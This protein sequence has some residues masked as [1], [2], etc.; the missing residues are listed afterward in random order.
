[1]RASPA[2]LQRSQL[3]SAESSRWTSLARIAR[4]TSYSGLDHGAAPVC[5]DRLA[6][7]ACAFVCPSVQMC[8]TGSGLRLRGATGVQF[9]MPIVTYR[10][11]P[12]VRSARGQT[13]DTAIVSRRR[14][15]RPRFSDRPPRSALWPSIPR[16]FFRFVWRCLSGSTMAPFPHPAHR[17]G[18]AGFPPLALPAIP[19]FQPMDCHAAAFRVS[20]QRSFMAAQ[21]SY[22][23]AQ[24]RP[25]PRSSRSRPRRRAASRAD[26]NLARRG[27]RE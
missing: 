26:C 27:R 10:R 2:L 23:T 22:A 25:R 15:R 4:G 24:A 7:A 19:Q 11:E 6:C 17:T 3:N 13:N 16:L 8:T 21:C 5:R 18:H 14:W 12:S 20:A 9:W 1:M